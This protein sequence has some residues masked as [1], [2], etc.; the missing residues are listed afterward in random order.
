MIFIKVSTKNRTCVET[1]TN[2]WT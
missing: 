1:S 2:L